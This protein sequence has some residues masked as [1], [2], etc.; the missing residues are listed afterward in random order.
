MQLDRIMLAT[1]A[2]VFVGGAS[3]GMYMGVTHE[4]QYAPVHAHAN[5]VG[6]ASLALF[7]VAYRIYPELQ[8]SKL[9]RAQAA[10]ALAS[11]PLFPI[12]LYLGLFQNF[13]VPLMIVPPIFLLSVVL[14]AAV[15]VR[16]LLAGARR[17]GRM[18][19]E[20]VVAAE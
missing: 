11:A 10:C 9:A 3:L 19:R 20:R 17:G 7:G 15:M 1:A 18:L 5:L 12:A 16:H 13:P 2:L 6:W 14:F 4:F 8:A